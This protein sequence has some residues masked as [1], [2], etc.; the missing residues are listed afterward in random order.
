VLER[1]Q[2]AD[3]ARWPGPTPKHAPPM[4][5]PRFP[6]WKSFW[7]DE[8]VSTITRRPIAP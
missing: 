6:T 5:L 1:P 8:D 2:D 4:M 7:G 3:F